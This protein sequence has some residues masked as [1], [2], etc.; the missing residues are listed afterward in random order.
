MTS[1]HTLHHYE[2]ILQ[3][4]K[5]YLAV[6]WPYFAALWNDNA[7]IWSYHAVL[8]PNLEALRPYFEA[9]YAYLA[10][11]L[12]RVTS[13]R[14][15]THCKVRRHR[16][17]RTSQAGTQARHNKSD[18]WSCYCCCYFW[19][20]WWCCY[21]CCYCCWRHCFGHLEPFWPRR[22]EFPTFGKNRL[23]QLRRKQASQPRN[24]SGNRTWFFRIILIHNKFQ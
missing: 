24:G 21:W 18:C 13:P 9:L 20:W 4:S 12:V 15:K 10:A 8:W 3:N 1:V 6:L 11:L 16:W 14:S 19:C 17:R 7:V 23:L 22:E 5:A 2:L